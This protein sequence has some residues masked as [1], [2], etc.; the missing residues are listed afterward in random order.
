MI[1]Q[2][3]CSDCPYSQATNDFWTY[4]CTYWGKIVYRTSGCTRETEE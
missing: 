4:W 3:K 1:K 2:C